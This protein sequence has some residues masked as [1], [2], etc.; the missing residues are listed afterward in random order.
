MPDCVPISEKR[1]A[2][3]GAIKDPDDP[4][5]WGYGFD[6]VSNCRWYVCPECAEGAKQN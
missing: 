5:E 4:R 6:F 2:E 3:C 1:C